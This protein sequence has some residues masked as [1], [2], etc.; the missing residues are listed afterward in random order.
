MCVNE[1]SFREREKME[2]MRV[3]KK[4]ERER[5]RRLCFKYEENMSP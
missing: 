1:E 4:L 2:L 5:E 3:F